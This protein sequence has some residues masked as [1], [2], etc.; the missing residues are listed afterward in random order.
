MLAGML[1]RSRPPWAQESNDWVW[2]RCRFATRLSLL[3]VHNSVLLW[4]ISFHIAN[5]STVTIKKYCNNTQFPTHFLLFTLFSGSLIS[6]KAA[7]KERLFILNFFLLVS[8]N[9]PL[10]STHTSQT[11]WL[12]HLLPPYR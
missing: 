12:I 10:I 6:K 8:T 3:V 5:F 11:L 7:S 1:S 2:L 9:H 4:Q